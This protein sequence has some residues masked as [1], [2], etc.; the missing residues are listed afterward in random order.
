M[1]R[2]AFVVGLWSASWGA[3]VG[4][5]ARPLARFARQV[6]G[7]GSP[8]RE[9]ELSKL[10]MAKLSRRSPL[11][12][13]FGGGVPRP[14]HAAFGRRSREL[15]RRDWAFQFV[16]KTGTCVCIWGSRPRRIR[17]AYQFFLFTLFGSLIML[18]GILCVGELF[19][20]EGRLGSPIA[21]LEMLQNGT[22]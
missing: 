3:V 10:S 7:I 8:V 4:S 19:F 14:K 17:A 21:F 15:S 16:F 20:I 1:D 9:L 12:H 2:L 5:L 6:F 22:Q 13:F 18:L 11:S